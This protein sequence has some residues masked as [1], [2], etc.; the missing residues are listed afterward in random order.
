VGSRKSWRDG[1]KQRIEDC[2]DGF[3]RGIINAADAKQRRREERQRREEERKENQRRR[4]EELRNREK[5]ERR[6]KQLWLDLEGWEKAKRIREYVAVIAERAE[7]LA[8]EEAQIVQV[9]EWIK[10]ATKVADAW[11]PVKKDV[12]EFSEYGKGIDSSKTW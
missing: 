3:I 4:E 9:Q 12:P 1:K 5:E 6:Q 8:P 10:W 11:D 7:T 2:I